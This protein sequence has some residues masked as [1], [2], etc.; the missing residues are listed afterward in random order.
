MNQSTQKVEVPAKRDQPEQ[1]NGKLPQ[2]VTAK[3]EV[4]VT[5]KS[6]EGLN[7]A[8][9]NLIDEEDFAVS[10]FDF[11]IGIDKGEWRVETRTYTKQDGTL[12]LYYNYRRRKSYVNSDKK[13]IIP[14]R[15]GG[16]RKLA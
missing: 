9:N 7:F 4:A 5:A 8:V 6:G 12:M 13:R 2:K 14:Y 10:D 16:K 11:Y 3:P 1:E 15:K